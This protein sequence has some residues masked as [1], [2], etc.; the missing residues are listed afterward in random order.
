[1]VLV[2]ARSD[3]SK[4]IVL[5]DA[6]LNS[7]RCRQRNRN[8]DNSKVDSMRFASYKETMKNMKKY[9]TKVVGPFT[10]NTISRL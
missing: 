5:L 7:L 1:M 2:Y 10:F 8:M 9:D 4:K 6:G 3:N